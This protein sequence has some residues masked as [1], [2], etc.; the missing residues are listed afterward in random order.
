MSE[1]TEKT[2]KITINEDWCKACGICVEFCPRDV[3]GTKKDGIPTIEDLRACIEC[4]LCELRCPDFA[5][6]VEGEDDE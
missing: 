2:V 1:Q 3:F 4:G 6:V 5:V